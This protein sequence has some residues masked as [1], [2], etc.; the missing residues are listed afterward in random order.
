LTRVDKSFELPD[1]HEHTGDLARHQR[2]S[3]ER[4]CWTWSASAS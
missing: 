4:E 3:A 1:K 2:A